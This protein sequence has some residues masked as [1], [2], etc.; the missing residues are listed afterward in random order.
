MTAFR[1]LL[2]WSALAALVVA[3]ASQ[4]SAQLLNG[5]PAAQYKYSTP[6]PP[7][8]ASPGTV[9]TR[10]GALHFIDS[11]P[12]QAST[13]KIYDNLDYQRAVQGYLLAIP[14]VNQVADRAAMLSLGPANATIP[15]WEH[16]VDSRT[17]G[18]TFN[19]NTPYSWF[20]VDL[21]NG[22]VVV[23]VPP[24]VLGTVNDMWYY[25]AGDV[26]LT[27]PDKGQGGKYLLLPPG[28]KGNVPD[29]YN[30]M[31]PRTFSNMIFWRSF[32]SMAT[33]RPVSTRSRN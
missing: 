15:I 26:G 32:L 13:E 28:Y 8:I 2:N 17:V 30:V 5:P 33:R 1:L 31:R 27:G 10:F 24:K 14:A 9:D 7:G 3:A 11:V 22:P 4:S 21:H 23:E 20:W 12:D 19:D 18:L 6:I 29:G 16:L 25:W